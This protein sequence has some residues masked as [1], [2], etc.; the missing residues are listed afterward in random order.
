MEEFVDSLYHRLPSEEAEEC[1]SGLVQATH[2]VELR[3]ANAHDLEQWGLRFTAVQ[4]DAVFLD[5][6]AW[7][8]KY[9][10]GPGGGALRGQPSAG[11]D[12]EPTPREGFH[13]ASTYQN[14]TFVRYH[15]S[16]ECFGHQDEC[17]GDDDSS[18]DPQMSSV[19]FSSGSAYS[20][21][22]D[23]CDGAMPPGIEERSLLT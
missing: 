21:R 3:I 22:D 15:E 7:R 9:G 18:D 23:A 16:D 2:N 19:D 6:G 11:V 13:R 4:Y 12:E 10:W 8:A 20:D 14:L 1:V 17:Y 5:D